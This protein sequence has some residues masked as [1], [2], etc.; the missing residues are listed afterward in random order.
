MAKATMQHEEPEEV[1]IQNEKPDPQEESIPDVHV[2]TEERTKDRPHSKVPQDGAPV[3]EFQI[4]PISPGAFEDVEEET[5]E[6]GPQT[7]ETF[8]S[9]PG[10]KDAPPHT[11]QRA[12]EFAA[13][14]ILKIYGQ[15]KA[16]L[17][18][19][20]VMISEKKMRQME[21][22]GEVNRNI[23]LPL[24]DGSTIL[25]GVAI[26]RHNA[27]TAKVI[28]E[29][30]LTQEFYDTAKPLL[31]EELAKRDIGLTNMQMLLAVTGEDL[32]NFGKALKP[33]YEDRDELIKAFKRATKAYTAAA[34]GHVHA[35]AP[36]PETTPPPP[37][38]PQ[39][40]E[41]REPSTAAPPD[42]QEPIVVPGA[43]QPG[44]APLRPDSI[45]TIFPKKRGSKPGVARGP[46]KK[47]NKKQK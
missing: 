28:N 42:V 30:A 16:T 19:W 20:I 23:V 43:A 33:L 13:D 36:N 10:L 45:T 40:A 7:E 26:N 37:P 22:R 18:T 1:T 2:F 24:T 11:K 39:Q 6:P 32:F 14:G 3:E 46:Y 8:I 41:R 17:A 15:G 47:K 34:Q 29:H 12:A 31:A 25:A 21:E 5:A 44:A 38:K 27:A 9:N 35:A 4:P